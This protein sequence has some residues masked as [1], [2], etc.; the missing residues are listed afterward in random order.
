MLPVTNYIVRK[1]SED[2]CRDFNWFWNIGPENSSVLTKGCA[3]AKGRS[4]NIIF[5]TL[6]TVGKRIPKGI[7]YW[8]LSFLSNLFTKISL[9]LS[10]ISIKYFCVWF[11][12][13]TD[14]CSFLGNNSLQEH[15]ILTTHP[16]RELHVP[17]LGDGYSLGYC[18][19]PY[20]IYSCVVYW[21]VSVWWR[22]AGT[23]ITIYLYQKFQTN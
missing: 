1:L 7:H 8:N 17:R 9:D 3:N 19:N 16:V 6:K 23:K 15:T 2:I 14:L 21:T 11:A 20:W 10:S 12:I 4:V 22:V 18:C 5:W 13:L